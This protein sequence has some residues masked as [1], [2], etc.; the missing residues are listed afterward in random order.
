[1]SASKHIDKICCIAL[2]FALLITFLLSNITQSEVLTVSAAVGYE[3][4]LFNTGTVHTIDIVMDDWDSFLEN[5]TDEK[6]VDCTVIID[7]DVY[8]NVGIRAKGNTSL[9]S[10]AN[11]GN[12][13]YSFKIEFDHYD[14]ANTYYGLDKLCLN[15]IIQDNTY[16]KDYLTYTLMSSFDVN[17]PLCSYAYITVNGKDWGLY[18]A[19]EAVEE[20]FLQRCYGS[21]YGELY[22]PDSTTMG[23]GRGNGRNFDQEK[24]D[25]QENFPP[26]DR[27]DMPD[28]PDRS[29]ST[30]M[31]ERP[32]RS[33]P[34]DMSDNPD[35]PDENENEFD[36]RKPSEY[37]NMMPP[38]EFGGMMPGAKDNVM[39]TNDVSLIY[40]DDEYNSYSNIFENAKTNITTSDKDRLIAS[41]KQL[42]EGENIADT[43]DMDAVIRYFVVHNFVLNFD[44]YTGSM[45]HNYYLYEKDGQLSMIP[46]DYNLAF[47]GFRSESDAT[48]LINYT[49]DT[50]VSG[51]TIDS[52]PMLAWIFNNEEYVEQYHHYFSEFISEYFD[53]GYFT[54]MIDSLSEMISPYVEKDPTKFCTY[55]E[56]QEGAATLKEFCILRAKSISGQL[57]DSI[58]STDTEQAQDDSSLIDGSHLSISAMGAMDKRMEPN[59]SEERSF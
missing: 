1:M 17:A 53:S 26:H 7:G 5:C 6:Y 37:G 8:R 21:D 2:I 54:D 56:F 30:D 48:A 55:Q 41:L 12:D 51:G 11:Y 27:T 22:K 47:G 10:V 4:R 58:P 28:R 44:S 35:L 29:G 3:S 16:M 24:F 38:D 52:R 15:N 31:P 13:R 45:I 57:N 14:N 18:L 23:G 32:D 49:I 9:T 19:V 33:G 59:I 25:E 40:T 36:G 42:N 43:V 20:S 39:G 50:P 46:W 34:T